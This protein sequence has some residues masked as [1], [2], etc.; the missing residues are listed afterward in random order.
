M[1]NLLIEEL[2]LLDAPEQKY[3]RAGNGTTILPTVEQKYDRAGIAAMAMQGL[4]SIDWDIK[5][6][7]IE[8][9]LAN[10]VAWQ[11]VKCA[12]ALIAELKRTE[13]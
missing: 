5:T 11:A 2:T 4:C 7:P 13:K 12:D 6:E 3:D 1:V 8:D 9:T 10:M